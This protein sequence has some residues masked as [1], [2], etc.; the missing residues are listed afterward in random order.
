MTS[1]FVSDLLDCLHSNNNFKKN[2]LGREEE[3]LCAAAS[4]M[5][6]EK[7]KGGGLVGRQSSAVSNH[8]SP[9]A[10][11]VSSVEASV[12][13]S[14]LPQTYTPEEKTQLDLGHESVRSFYGHGD[15]LRKIKLGHR[16]ATADCCD[17]GQ[18]VLMRAKFEVRATPLQLLAYWTGCTPVY[19]ARRERGRSK[20][21]KNGEH[22]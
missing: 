21:L 20:T 7:M 15:S 14:I 3:L 2:F 4:L 19:L 13:R 22:R 5:L 12:E 8:T 17:T 1:E 10:Q 16:L 11:D 9:Y 18:E 6:G